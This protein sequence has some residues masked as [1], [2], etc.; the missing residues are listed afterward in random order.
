[1]IGRQVTP[2]RLKEWPKLGWFLRLIGWLLAGFCSVFG[3]LWLI[4][5]A[6]HPQQTEMPAGPGGTA[7]FAIFSF[8]Q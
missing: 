3:L 1:L 6:K 7:Q 5:F 8:R 2:E 4:S